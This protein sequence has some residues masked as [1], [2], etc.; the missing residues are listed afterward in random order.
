MMYPRPSQPRTTGTAWLF[1]RLAGA[2]LTAALSLSLV[3]PQRVASMGMAGVAADPFRVEAA[4]FEVTD[5]TF[6]DVT[7]T[8]PSVREQPEL[9]RRVVKTPNRAGAAAI[10]AA[11]RSAPGTRLVRMR[12]TAYCP[13]EI[14]CGPLAAGITASGHRVNVDQGKFVAADPVLAFGTR[15]VIPGYNEGQAVRVLDRGGAIRGRSLDVYF[16]DHE[17]ARQWGVRYLPVAIITSR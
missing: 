16:D 2:G 6:S 8:A 12:V 1:K 3:S 14:C 9:L 15:L 17:V 7:D 5:S 10:L 4:D 13:C 11:A